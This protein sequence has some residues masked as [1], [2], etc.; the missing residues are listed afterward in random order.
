MTF[1]DAHSFLE[2]NHD[3]VVVTFRKNGAAQASFVTCGLLQGG[4]VFTTKA[5][6]AKLANLK[7]DPRCTL[8]V[9]TPNRSSYVVVEGVA[10]IW[11]PDRTEAEELRLALRQAY[12]ACAGREHPNWPEYDCA[13]TEQKRS[14][15]SVK[16]QHVYGFTR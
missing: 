13:M 7:R 8:L 15:I 4:V 5:G 16:P 10:D 14:A 3:C 9:S 6:A 11:G 2:S 1:D 12:T